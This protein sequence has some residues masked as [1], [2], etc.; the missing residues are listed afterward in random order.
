MVY[1]PNTEAQ[2]QEMLAAMGL[3]KVEDL[4]QEVPAEVLNPPIDLPAP[5]SEPQL[6]AEM[7]RLSELNA[8]AAHYATFLGAGSY[9]HFSPSAVY[10][11]MSRNEFYT[12]YTPYQPELSQGILQ[13]IY[14]FQT[15]VCQLTGMDVANASM[16]DAASA[17]GE[18]AVMAANI[19]KRKKV[20]VSPKT[21]P[22]HKAVLRTYADCHGIEIV[23]RDAN[24]RES[25]EL[26]PDTACVIVQ[27]PN[28][29]GEI[30]DL[31]GLAVKVHEAGAILIILFD[32]ISLAILK[33]PGEYDAD[34]AIGEGQS[35]GVPMSF[36]GPYVGLFAT[37]EKYVRNM[38]GRLAGMTKDVHGKRGFVLTLQTRE[39]HI[40]REKATSNICTNEALIA[41]A[42]TAYMCCMGPQGL[43]RVAQLSLQHS[44]YLAN[45]IARLPGY[46]I[47]SREPFFKEFA[48]QTPISP[49]ELNRRLLEHKIIGGLDISGTKE[50]DG[51]E[52]VWLLAATEMN[53]REQMDRLVVALEGMENE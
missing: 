44:H 13:Q 2:R 12:A 45:R 23:E 14:E 19:T 26:D 7:R 18:A 35:L 6:M 9:N 37:K 53:S 24:I 31:N 32:P 3:S 15:L 10:R 50:V 34:I 8:D 46:K 11:I 29:L 17:L 40:R 20:V 48:V 33:S 49:T 52:N 30:R 38:P 27:Q 36:G 16:Y 4:Y 42:A 22:E 43:K 39:Q 28:F 21:H 51:L 1:T 25:S 47:I 41:L 5:L